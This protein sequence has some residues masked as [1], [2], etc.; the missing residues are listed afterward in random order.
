MREI[1]H[2]NRSKFA[3][4]A[5][6]AD[7]LCPRQTFMDFGAQLL[8]V[9]QMSSKKEIQYLREMCSL[10]CL[11]LSRALPNVILPNIIALKRL[12]LL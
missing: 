9:P 7:G 1:D 2:R 8:I 10:I 4:G 12:G 5:P 3:I 6:C 11:S